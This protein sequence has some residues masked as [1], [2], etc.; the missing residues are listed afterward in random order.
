[1]GFRLSSLIHS[2]AGALQSIEAIE[3]SGSGSSFIHFDPICKSDQDAISLGIIEPPWTTN[4]VLG[5]SAWNPTLGLDGTW[6]SNRMLA[7]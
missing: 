7:L 3:E 5:A 2:I 6:F 1:M 4:L